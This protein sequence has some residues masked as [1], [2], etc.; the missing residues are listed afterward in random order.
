M[1]VCRNS[2]SAI[3]KRNVRYQALFR[4]R[5]RVRVWLKACTLLQHPESEGQDRICPR[6]GTFFKRTLRKIGSRQC[7]TEQNWAIAQ[8]W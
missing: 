3:R 7:S 1:I 4:V 2:F 6:T 5:V 8:S